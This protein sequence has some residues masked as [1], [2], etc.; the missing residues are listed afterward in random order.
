MRLSVIL[1]LAASC[2]AQ[3]P[4]SVSSVLLDEDSLPTLGA[5]VSWPSVPLATYTVYRY[6]L[7]NWKDC[8]SGAWVKLASGLTDLTYKDFPTPNAEGYGS[9][10]CY[11]V[12]ATTNGVESAITPALLP[13]QMGL[14]FYFMWAYW[15][16]DCD[17]WTGQPSGSGTLAINLTH[18]DGTAVSIPLVFVNGNSVTNP[19][20]WAGFARVL[21]SDKIA[22]TL[23]LPDGKSYVFPQLFGGWSDGTPLRANWDGYFRVGF[24]PRDGFCEKYEW[25]NFQ[26]AFDNQ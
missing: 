20:R 7:Y 2:F 6:E 13:V 23:V 10:W 24:D 1:L 15:S 9:Q 3:A 14:K 12:S 19:P 25:G 22:A 21:S 8:S 17:T 5:Q 26:P 4:A 18:K 16:A 11:G